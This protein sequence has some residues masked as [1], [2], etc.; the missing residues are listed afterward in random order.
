MPTNPWSRC[1]GRARAVL[2][3]ASAG[4]LPL[5]LT[6]CSSGSASDSDALADA[7]AD[8][9]VVADS[10]AAEQPNTLTAAEQAAGWRLLW[11]GKSFDGWRGLG[12]DT[13]PT[14]HWKIVD[15]AIYKVPSGDVPLAPDGQPLAGGDLMTKDTFQN[16]ELS[17]DWKISEGGNSGLKYNVDEGL[18]LRNPT[19]RAALGFE[20]QMLDDERHPD[21]QLRT[22]RAAALYDL[23]PPD[24]TKKHLNPVGEWNHS[25]VVFNGNHGEHW[26]NGQKVVEYELGSPRM[27]SAFAK[28]K[29]HDM[30]EFITRKTGHIVLQ[31]HNDGVWIRNVKIR[32]L[33]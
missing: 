26:L 32:E 22:H 11:D 18:S 5:A 12:R 7:A 4:L 2:A 9:A 19:A 29:W 6:A 20:Y 17:W 8:P 13:V 10:T 27:D 24:S 31:D 1:A 3:L 30:P 33:E 15:A 23:I 21:G 28:S 16:F 14:Q 25:R